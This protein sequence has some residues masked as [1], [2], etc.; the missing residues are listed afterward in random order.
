[1]V[2]YGSHRTTVL[3]PLYRYIIMHISL[4]HCHLVAKNMV[5]IHTTHFLLY[6]SIKT[7]FAVSI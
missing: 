5:Y 2:G 4:L 1:M 6:D 3:K 7:V